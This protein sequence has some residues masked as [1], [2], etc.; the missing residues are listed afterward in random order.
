M[1]LRQ[2]LFRSFRAHYICIG[3]R[4]GSFDWLWWTAF[5]D[6]YICT[7]GLFACSC[8]HRLFSLAWPF[9]SFPR[10]D[11]NYMNSHIPDIDG[12][13]RSIPVIIHAL[14]DYES[15]MNGRP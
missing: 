12:K 13:V 10:D 15:A 8:F 11:M 5:A 4:L 3:A 7:F 9:S 6:F 2:N 1:H 14:P